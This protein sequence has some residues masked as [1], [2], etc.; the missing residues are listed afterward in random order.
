MKPVVTAAEMRALDRATIDEIGLPA[1]TLMET[2]GRAVAEA[3]LRDARRGRGHVA[4]VCGPGNNGGDGFV[5]ARVLR[6]RGLDAVVVP[7][8]RRA[9]RSRGDAR[10]APRR[11]SSASGGVVRI[12]RDARRS[13]PTLGDAIAGAALVVDALFGVGLARADRGSPRR[14]RRGDQSRAARGSRST[15]RRGSTPTPG[16]TLGAARARRAHRDDGAR[17]RSRWS[18]A[19]GFAR[20]GEIEVADIGIP[21]ALIATP[22]VRAGARRG[23]RRRALAA[24][25]AA[26]SITRA[27]AATC[28]SSAARRACAAPAG[29]PRS[30]RCAPGPGSCTLAAEGDVDRAGLGDD[31]RARPAQLGE[32]LDGK[33]AVVIGRGLGHGERGRAL[34]R[35]R[36]SRPACPRCSTPTR[37]TCSPAE[38]EALATRRRPGRA[39]AASRRGGAAARHRPSPTI[40][41]DRLAAARALAAR[42]RAVVVL[43]GARTIVCDGTL[44]DDYCAIN[45]TGG[46]AL[47]HRRQRRR[48]RRRD[49]RAAR[50]GRSARS[51]P[52]AP[53]CSST[54]APATSSRELHGARGVMSSDLPLAVATCSASLTPRVIPRLA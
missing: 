6:E 2:A 19:P 52:R 37:S 47:A 44:G 40:E 38:P 43:K 42:T 45:P 29:S 7:R 1:L 10:G 15:S 50:A 21:A 17:S 5:V 41:A 39:H 27:R 31:A 32:L 25:A 8:G 3:A 11:S 46:P 24:A 18:S 22:G 14:G 28:W 33:A 49:R 13:S 53:A 36:C 51:M 12:D 48:A 23:R 54:A 20:C 16:A 9:T 30:R 26:R 4:V 35:A 34:G